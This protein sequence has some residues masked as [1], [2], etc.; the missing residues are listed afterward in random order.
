MI[1]IFVVGDVLQIVDLTQTFLRILEEFLGSRVMRDGVLLEL[2]QEPLTNT[3][4][5]DYFYEFL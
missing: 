4:H 2:E 1:G 3:L 5:D